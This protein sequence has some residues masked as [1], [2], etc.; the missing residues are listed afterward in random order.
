MI[1]DC[2][3]LSAGSMRVRKVVLVGHGGVKMGNGARDNE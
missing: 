3:V 1:T 2:L